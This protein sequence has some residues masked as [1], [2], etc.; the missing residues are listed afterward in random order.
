MSLLLDFEPKSGTATGYKRP[1]QGKWTYEDY[2]RLPEDGKIYEIIEGEL[3]MSPAPQTRH[4]I[5][6]GNLFA[7]LWI[8]NKRYHLGMVLDAPSDIILGELA[9][10]VQPDII[11]ILKDHLDIVK[12]ERVEGAPDLAV[13]VLSPWNWKIDRGKKSKIYAKAGVR[14]YW[15]VDPDKRTIELYHLQKKTYKLIGKYKAGESVHSK[16]LPG[17]AVQVE[18][19]CP[20]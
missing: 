1:P 14:E 19:V 16:I 4:Q 9:S 20:E 13:E 2:C 5:C 11:F 18:E 15:I 12:K 8:H 3:F 6:K 17:F 10:P 7:A